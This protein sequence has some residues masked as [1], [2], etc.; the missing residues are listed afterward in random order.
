[1]RGRQPLPIQ[2]GDKFGHLTALK[3]VRASL[4]GHCWLFKCDCGNEVVRVVRDVVRGRGNSR[5][6]GCGRQP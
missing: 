6:C 2:A 1:M 4:D 5:S 3:F